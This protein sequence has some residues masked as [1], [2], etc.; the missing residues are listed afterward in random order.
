MLQAPRE[1][2]LRYLRASLRADPGRREHP[3]PQQ[4]RCT[5][6][7]EQM[8]QAPREKHLRY[9]RA[10]LRADPGRREHP[11]P[12]QPRCTPDLKQ[13]LQAPRYS[14][15]HSKHYIYVG[16]FAHSSTG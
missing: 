4:A 13:M 1:K 14:N 7:L 15:T 16:F 6:V 12:Q 8:L 11:F 3:L 5:P 10:S 2:H 9:L